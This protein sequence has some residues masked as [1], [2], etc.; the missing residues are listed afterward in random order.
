MSAIA[1][2]LGALLAIGVLLIVVGIASPAQPKA[3]PR[4]RR[5]SDGAIGE[6][7][8][9]RLGGALGVGLVVFLLTQ[10]VV[11]AV[12]GVATVLAMPYLRG[13]QSEQRVRLAKAEALPVWCE[14]LRDLL[15]GAHGLET[16]IKTTAPV[17]P[18]ALRHD[19]QLLAADL[20]RMSLRDALMAFADRVADPICDQVVMGLRIEGGEVGSVL[21]SIADS[22]RNA[23]EVR[24][25]VESGR[26][27]TRWTARFTIAVTVLFALGL[28]I[29]DRK[30]LT[31]YDGWG[32]F[33]LVIVLAFFAG[34][35]WLMA[36]VT[37]GEPPKRLLDGSQNVVE[38]RP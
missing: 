7:T 19:T 25:R 33:L 20:G 28:S 11:M 21:G 9:L 36:L 5:T 23:L 4:V 16:V 35:L 14:M 18:V 12:A 3:T 38:V 13:R 17:A 34:G 8:V 26:A 15:Q 31:A 6:R 24:R 37:R 2:I 10:W 30:Y 29:F 1:A 22:A 32:Q 27:S